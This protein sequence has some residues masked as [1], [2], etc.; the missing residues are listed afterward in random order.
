VKRIIISDTHIGSKYYKGDELLEFLKHVE[1]DELILAGDIIDFIRVPTFTKRAGEIASA[2]D[3]SKSIYYIVGNHDS[4]LK[5]FIG[6]KFFGIKFVDK[7]EF[8]ECGRK[9][10]VVHG[11]QYDISIIHYSFFMSILSIVQ[12]LFERTFNF[13]LSTWWTNLKLKRRKLRRIWDILSWNDDADVFIMGHSHVPECVVWI[14]DEQ[15]VKTYAN[16]GDWV[17]K[18]TYIEITDGI[19]RLKKYE[20]NENSGD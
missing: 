19:L 15:E 7:L 1:Y 20:S 10:R 14:N 8:E 4:P 6:Y 18:K 3:Y 5:G 2:I 13:D 9:F 16:S 17:F 12:D 11:D